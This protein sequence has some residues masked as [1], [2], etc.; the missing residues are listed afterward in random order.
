[1][2][3][4]FAVITRPSAEAEPESLRLIVADAPGS[5]SETSMDIVSRSVAKSA[6]S[7]PAAVRRSRRPDMPS[8]PPTIVLRRT[9]R[10]FRSSVMVGLRGAIRIS[11]CASLV[12]GWRGAPRV[13]QGPSAVSAFAS[14]AHTSRSADGPKAG[15][16]SHVRSS[17][18]FSP[19]ARWRKYA[20]FSVGMSLYRSP[21]AL[22]AASRSRTPAAA[23]T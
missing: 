18:L 20:P 21:R 22:R 14:H 5:E 23:A 17:S 8:R 10:S 15:A 2:R 6:A 9:E 3:S 4:V 13:S 1:M 7:L 19:D 12:G 16:I 11:T